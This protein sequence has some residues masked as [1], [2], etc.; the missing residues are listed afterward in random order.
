MEDELKDNKPARPEGEERTE[1]VTVRLTPAELHTLQAGVEM[2]GERSIA[3]FIRRSALL[4][5]AANATQTE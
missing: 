4:A 3:D 5:A 2:T 1:H